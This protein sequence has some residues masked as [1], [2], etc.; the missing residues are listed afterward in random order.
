MGLSNLIT[1]NFWWKRQK[2]WKSPSCRVNDELDLTPIEDAWIKK[3]RVYWGFLYLW[4]KLKK[5]H[6]PEPNNKYLNQLKFYNSYLLSKI[7][8]CSHPNKRLEET[9]KDISVIMYNKKSSVMWWLMNQRQKFLLQPCF[10]TV[11]ASNSLSTHS[12]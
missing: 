11:L 9:C 1:Q 6:E 3:P 2:F 5:L 12:R 7:S 8:K 10:T 4:T